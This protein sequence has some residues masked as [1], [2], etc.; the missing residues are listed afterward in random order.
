MAQ[1]PSLRWLHLKVFVAPLARNPKTKAAS[2]ETVEKAGK[3]LSGTA[4]EE[5]SAR[6]ISAL[7][8]AT[9]EEPLVKNV[10]LPRPFPC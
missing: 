9:C 1:A 5:T 2:T 4:N 7:A 10:I 8:N 3:G 6:L